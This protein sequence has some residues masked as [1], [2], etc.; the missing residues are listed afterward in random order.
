MAIED[1]KKFDAQQRAESRQ[2]L[3]EHL[4]LRSRK[5][6]ACATSA[7]RCWPIRSRSPRQF[8]EN[9]NGKLKKLRTE[10]HALQAVQQPIPR[11]RPCRI[12]SPR[13][14][15]AWAID[16]HTQEQNLRAEAQRGIDD[17]QSIRERHRSLQRAEGHPL[18]PKTRIVLGVTGGHCRL[19][20]S[21]SGAP[22]DGTR[23]GRASGHDGR[24]AAIRLSHD[25]S[26]RIGPADPQRSVGRS[27]GSRHGPHRA[28]ALGAGGADRAGQRGFHCA[29]GRRPR[30]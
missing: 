8:L 13:I 30:R 19:Q 20:E 23:R 17:E 29:H 1:Q 14:W 12:K 28:R 5:S 25:L 11:P 21:G 3:A 18:T 6:N 9:L 16:I 27:G 26:G 10:Q 4:L 2:E 7:S 24:R 22:A 15:C